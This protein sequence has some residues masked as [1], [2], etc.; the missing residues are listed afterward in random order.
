MN[1]TTA[2]PI[3]GST[4][5]SVNQ[6]T[7]TASVPS[8]SPNM[9]VMEQ[10]I[11]NGN[12]GSNITAS[13]STP[14]NMPSS[15]ASV[16]LNKTATAATQQAINPAPAANPNAAAAS[17]ISSILSKYG[18]PSVSASDIQGLLDNKYSLQDA[19]TLLTGLASSKAASDA[20]NQ[21]EQNA[22]N[23]RQA[24][25]DADL[26]NQNA[27]YAQ[28][29]QQLATDRQNA[30][31][32]ATQQLGAANSSAI[33]SDN[34][35]MISHI[36]SQYDMAQQ[37]LTL[38][39]QQA[40]AALDSGNAT[41]YNAIVANMSN[42]RAQLN[43]NIQNLISG[44]SS[45]QTNEAAAASN[46]A[47]KV[48]AQKTADQQKSQGIADK[49][50]QTIT[51]ESAPQLAALPNDTATFTPAQMAT[52]QGTPGYSALISANLSP[53]DALGYIKNAATG[54]SQISK[55]NALAEKTQTDTAKAQISLMN[56]QANDA[57]LDAKTKDLEITQANMQSVASVKG[58][59]YMDA[60]NTLG[61]NQTTAQGKQSLNTMA[62]LAQGGDENGMKQNLVNDVTKTLPTADQGTFTGIYST[63]VAA[64]SLMAKI[65][66]LPASQKAGIINGNIQDIATKFG[67]NPDPALQ[68]VAAEAAH[69]STLYKANVFG[70]RAV[71][72]SIP[73]LDSLLG[74]AKNNESL[75]VTD[76]QAFQ[77]TAN[78]VLGGLLQSKIGSD[79]YQKIFGDS[80][81]MGTSAAP[82]ASTSASDQ[83]LISAFFSQGNFSMK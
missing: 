76:I 63:A 70:K 82:A 35:G 62:A 47:D 55:E 51:N 25:Y 2:A 9:G 7:P 13:Q 27:T 32:A 42:V 29:S 69:L 14:S 57:Y 61:N 68:S 43:T 52:L 49:E 30:I 44:V 24:S 79:S 36:G 45:N 1:P 17:S 15:S 31:G 67:Q 77:S 59:A 38:Q 6:I 19:T 22:Q 56:A 33:S 83:S 53:N 78:D 4:P 12:P 18:G 39:A 66:A 5:T 71:T 58:G 81:A 10:S 16:N 34:T 37:T 64:G 28:E 46:E 23:A 50:L 73:G 21:D 20:A 26:A 41:A 54:N 3:P 11:A 65:Q 60:L 75:N 8:Q 80:G 40:K 48:A 74:S 72:S